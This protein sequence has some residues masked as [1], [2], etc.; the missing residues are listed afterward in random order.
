MLQL[1]YAR[2]TEP[3]MDKGVFDGFISRNKA[4]LANRA[5]DPN[6]VF[7]DTVNAVLYQGNIRRSAPSVAKLEQVNLKRAFEI[8]KE[9]FADASNFT[10]ALMGNFEVNVIKPLLEKYLGGLPSTHKGENYKDLGIHLP[11]GRIEK[12]VY[13]GIEPKAKVNL[14]FSGVFDYSAAEKIQL[15]GLKEVLQIRLTERLRE[16]ESGVYSPGV[17]ESVSKYP[18]PSYSFGISF[19]CSPQNVEK[20]IASVLDEI[21]K[22]KTSGPLQVNVDKY[23]AEDQRTRETSLKSNNWWMD[24]LVTSLQ[25]H[26]DLHELNAYDSDMS[27]VTPETL[28]AIANKYLSG[29]N[30]IRLVLLPEK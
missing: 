8:Y 5:N 18:N 1:A 27:K 22:L 10:F 21:N 4:S 23:K 30:Y 26:D 7:S 17:S 25:N 28:K 11:T 29:K 14:F 12:T 16:D 13:K 24:Y 2:F 9:R 6:S 3:R 15:D 20:L 19:G